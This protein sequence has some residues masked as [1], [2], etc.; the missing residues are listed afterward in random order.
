MRELSVWCAYCV[1]VRRKCHCDMKIK[2]NEI[3]VLKA[4]NK[5]AP[6]FRTFL[7]HPHV[8]RKF[9]RFFHNAIFIK[10]GMEPNV[11]RSGSLRGEARKFRWR[12]QPATLAVPT[13]F[14]DGAS[15]PPLRCQKVSATAP[16][17]HLCG[18]RKVS[19][20]LPA[21]NLFGDRKFR[22]RHHFAVPES[23][24]DGAQ[25]CVVIAR[26]MEA[27]KKSLAGPHLKLSRYRKVSELRKEIHVFGSPPYGCIGDKEGTKLGSPT[28]R[29][30]ARASM[31]YFSSQNAKNVS[32]TFEFGTRSCLTQ[33]G[34]SSNSNVYSYVFA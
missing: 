6:T 24:G 3:I 23:F 14:G 19:A 25:E 34:S 17:R 26:D 18:A 21:R 2:L 10:S 1:M 22:R 9:R 13:S 33:R 16:A 15:P 27:S 20:S 5:S 28:V 4:R 30:S 8:A 31:R 11:S 29:H 32:E 12:R 7:N